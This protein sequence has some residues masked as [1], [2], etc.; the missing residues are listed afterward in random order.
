M[1]QPPPQKTSKV[2]DFLNGID[3]LTVGVE[4]LNGAFELLGAILQIAVVILEGIVTVLGAVL[5]ALAAIG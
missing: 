2:A 5:E 4:V 3:W 1:I